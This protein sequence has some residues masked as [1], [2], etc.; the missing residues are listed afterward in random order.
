MPNMPPQL[1]ALHTQRYSL[2]KNHKP[3]PQ[4]PS[5]TLTNP[6]FILPDGPLANLSSPPRYHNR[7]PSPS[8]LRNDDNENDI[9]DDNNDDDPSMPSFGSR[10]ATATL[11]AEK[12]RMGMMGRKMMLIRGKTGSNASSKG[13]ASP[14]P[15]NSHIHTEF[16]PSSPVLQDVGNL[17]PERNEAAMLQPPEPDHRRT[18]G[19]SSS[20]ISGISNFLDKYAAID[21]GGTSDDETLLYGSSAHA[22]PSKHGDQ[23]DADD[24]EA[25]QRRK[26]E[27][28]ELNS[29]I[30]SK[31]AEQILAN[32]KIRLNVME[33]NLRGA[34]DLV[35]PLTSAN[36]KRAASVG[37]AHY[38]AVYGNGRTLGY[39]ID[40]DEERAL[41]SPR[42]LHTQQ[43]SPNIGF[44]FQNHTRGW[45]ETLPE[46]S[47]TALDNHQQRPTTSDENTAS[48]EI[49]QPAGRDLRSSRSFDYLGGMAYKNGRDHTLH[50]M[51]SAD[52]NHLE[53]LQEDD[54]RRSTR[55]SY[56]QLDTDANNGL[57]IYRPASRTSD[58]RDQMSSLKT[59]ISTLKERAREDSLRRQSQLDLRQ[60]TLFNNARVTPPELF[61]TASEQY[62][63][64]VLDTN[65][66]IGFTADG[67]FP[68]ASPANVWEAGVPL[69]GSRNA[70]AQ[71]AAMQ[72]QPPIQQARVVN[73]TKAQKNPPTQPVPQ[74][75]KRT[76]SG[77]AVIDSAKNR[78]SHHQKSHSKS[79]QASVEHPQV[80]LPSADE[81][82]LEMLE[83]ELSSDQYDSSSE[84]STH[85]SP[86]IV[87]QPYEPSESEGMSV[88]ED[89]NEEAIPPVVAHEDRED[90]F[91]Y[92]S[93]FLHSAMKNLGGSRRGSTSSEASVSSASTA[94]GPALATPN[95]NATFDHSAIDYPPP[96]P[97]T[98][99]KLRQI[100]RNLHKRA[101]SEDSLATLDTYATAEEATPVSPIDDRE[102]YRQSAMNHPRAVSPLEA[103]RSQSRREYTRTP[104]R[105]EYSRSSSRQLSTQEYSRSNSRQLSSRT[106]S[107]QEPDRKHSRLEYERK[108]SR[109]E[110]R[111]NESRQYAERNHS[112]QDS[113]SSQRTAST[114]RPVESRQLTSRPSMTL[115]R[116]IGRRNSSSDRADSGVGITN[117]SQDGKR[118]SPKTGVQ[119]HVGKLS[120][121]SAMS[122]TS[123]PPLS[124]IEK[125][126]KLDPATI[127]VQALLDP[128]GEPLGL[129]NK[130]VLFGVVESL[131]RV[132][133]QMQQEEESTFASRMLRNQLDEAKR[134]LDGL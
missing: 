104:S 112:R 28:E 51:Q 36:L 78:Y 39:T 29:A 58:I 94:R 127:A 5:P 101:Y 118:P 42:K 57:G 52:P 81:A 120:N 75:H 97:E 110:D 26:K 31:R 126:T 119:K 6:E 40:R 74:F 11:S 92:E 73:I 43:S 20:G 132:V 41:S 54:E 131:R 21:E 122:A 72:R 2:D 89:A 30:L 100:E 17:A 27:Q 49:D 50:S 129:R 123:T 63:S 102:D 56:A 128:N 76:P 109:Q 14:R 60:P 107:R 18:S 130:A 69:T 34:R 108:Q 3:L 13:S 16:I 82:F 9:D 33:G 1:H 24:E 124:P 44:D 70:F 64:P 59:K 77:T 114:S 125:P 53:P 65:A 111:R 103:P 67:N 23:A 7:P 115:P 12:E 134:T 10:S 83:P 105:H 55:N 86:Q 121:A 98:P 37:S 48:R 99:E 4:L 88:Y 62:G 38:S 66:G 85:P 91:D 93:F 116:P 46:R 15:T 8:Y 113:E 71:Q 95:A 45:S 84:S 68:V 79:S 80:P 133:R 61:Y 96:T 90:A 19:S 32:A 35:A 25:A 106:Q 22:T 87:Q 117:R 47:Y